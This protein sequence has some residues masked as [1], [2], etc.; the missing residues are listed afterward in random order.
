MNTIYIRAAT[1]FQS[2]AR[3]ISIITA[4]AVL[5]LTA[6][7]S[8]AVVYT[9]GSSTTG[10]S[11]SVTTNW[12]PNGAPT[13]ADTANLN[14]ATA[15]RIVSYDASASGTLSTLSFT[16]SSAFKNELQIQKQLTVAN[17]ITLGA[18]SGM[19][20]VYILPTTT[21][22][23]NP[24][25][26]GGISV[27]SGGMLSMGAYNPT[28]SPSVGTAYL[29]GNV[30]IAGGVLELSDVVK[31]GSMTSGLTTT[32]SFNN[33]L[34]MSSGTIAFMNSGYTDRR[35]QVTGNLNISGGAVTAAGSGAGFYLSGTSNVFNPTTFDSASKITMVLQA[36]TDQ[37]IST[38][39][40]IGNVVV[41]GYGVRTFTTSSGTMAQL[42]LMDGGGSASQATTFKLGSNLTQTGNIIP[43]SFGNTLEAGRIDLGID[44]D[45]YTLTNTNAGGFT[46]TTS[47]QA[48]VTNTVWNLSGTSGTFKA[49]LFNFNS[50]TTTVNVNAGLTLE[51]TGSN[52]TAN[53][54]SGSGTINSTSIFR[55]SGG[56][57]AATPA[58][59]TSSRNI[60]DLEVTSGALRLSLTGTAQNL[61]IGGTST[62]GTLDLNS[63][64]QT[65]SSITL[66]SGTLTSGTA[67]TA[68]AIGVQAG[69]VSAVLDGV[70]ALTKTGTGVVTLSGAN[71]YSGGSNINAGT[72]SMGSANA[73]GSSG[74]IAFGGGT[75]QYSASGTTDYS[76]R[77]STAASQAYSLDTNGQSVVLA[78]PLT[79]SG[80]SLTKL[81]SGTLT[82]ST[83]NSFNGDTR[84]AAGTLSLG[85]VNALSAS[86][87][88]M[89]VADAG[90]IGFVTGTTQTYALAGLKGARNIANAGNTLSVGGNG[91]STIYSGVLSGTG[92]LTKSGAGSLT[93]SGSNTFTGA[94]NLNS[95]TL[96]L[97]GGAN[98]LATG[99]TLNFTS[100]ATLTVDNVSQQLSKVTVPDATSTV[101]IGGG[102]GLTLTTGTQE[103]GVGGNTITSQTSTVDLAGLSAFT[104]NN[105][106]GTFRVG[107]KTSGNGTNTQNSVTTV[108][109]PATSTITASILAVS[110]QTGSSHGGTGVLHLGASNTVNA[111]TIGVG[112]GRSFGTLDFTSG[113]TATFRG[114]AGGTSAVSTWTV[115]LVSTFNSSTF[116]AAADFSTGTIDANVGTLTIGVAEAYNSPNRA[117][118]TNGTFSMG[119]GTLTGGTI[120]I[121]RIQAT[122]V[123]T[124]PGVG[125][126]FAGNGVFN[127]NGGVVD[128]QTIELA[129]NQLAASAGTQ[130]VSGTF[131][132]Q[133]GTLRAT[134]IGKGAQTG[135]ATASTGFN[136]TSGTI[137]NKAGSDLAINSLPITLLAGTHTFKAA[138]GSSITLDA[139]SGISGSGGLTKTGSGTL[140]VS[141]SNSYS[142]DTALIAGKMLVNGSLA[143]AVNVA[144]GATLGGSGAVFSAVSVDGIISPG[145]SPGILSMNTLTL[146]SSATTIIEIAAEGVRGTGFDGIDILTNGGLTYGGAL[147]LAFGAS[148]FGDN[149]SFNI[150]SFGGTPTGD[151][152]TVTS[153]GYYDGAWSNVGS[154]QW[155]S[156]KGS[157]TLT[158]SQSAGTLVVVPEPA[159]ILSAGIGIAIAGWTAW[160][161]RRA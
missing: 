60:G 21:A 126:T 30:T 108:T 89:N 111:N 13:T 83:S 85:N 159:A 23:L 110:D 58:T 151:F 127:L 90:S 12:S 39:V 62:V 117:G 2:S 59:L 54:L 9:W 51:S 133:A 42:A 161:R 37:A 140:I 96:A 109:L 150:F 125:N 35:L 15:D 149:A 8:Q 81:G 137:E 138:S 157:Q 122:G 95:G 34:T 114:A 31:S 79:S 94:I 143:S 76:S 11:W 26:T 17:A 141:G 50:G 4:V 19:A 107:L 128:A 98:R 27:N 121:G 5:A 131:N 3:M 38:S 130:R 57:A 74:T 156:V 144:G 88:D 100:S 68:G 22:V 29:N 48:S 56:A 55:Y 46:P 72:L 20:R 101:T 64:A 45:R 124:G 67:T 32:N 10:G 33:N 75:L 103:F 119:A 132:L 135:G 120:S 136:W 86:T 99:D 16:Q 82:L 147:S 24:V 41:R 28:G 104:Y 70:G 105:S 118:T 115:G 52:S 112:Q 129:T 63:S 14:D 116:S 106:G 139:A 91:Q 36:T 78:T 146:S 80:G 97:T 65:F 77:F 152:A 142:G 134:S 69:R 160:K 123:G 158:F 93:L 71:T 84:I 155:Q 154:G 40:N 145:N 153:T 18:S 92:G 148:P 113:G 7:P 87:L 53:V 49:V 25:F 47:T 1:P 43:N 73:L 66:T 6:A 44:V 61:R 102:G